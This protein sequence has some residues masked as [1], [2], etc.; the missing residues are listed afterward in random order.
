MFWNWTH[1]PGMGWI[2]ARF[3]V[4]LDTLLGHFGDGGLAAVS[5]TIVATVRAHRITLHLAHPLSTKRLIRHC[6]IT[7]NLTYLGSPHLLCVVTVLIHITCWKLGCDSLRY[8][9]KQQWKQ[10]VAYSQSWAS[11]FAL[12]RRLNRSVSYTAE[13]HSVN[14]LRSLLLQLI[15]N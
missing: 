6:G 8:W 1:G 7:Q 13:H 3:N 9:D 15:P 14:A 4:P 10:L 2:A 12:S 11:F 5:A